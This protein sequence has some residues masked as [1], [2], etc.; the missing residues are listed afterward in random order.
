MGTDTLQ[1]AKAR[2]RVFSAVAKAIS[3]SES[4]RSVLVEIPDAVLKII[5][6]VESAK[7]NFKEDAISLAYHTATVTDKTVRFVDFVRA[8]PSMMSRIA[9]FRALLGQISDEIRV[10]VGRRSV[11]KLLFN[12]SRSVSKLARMRQVVAEAIAVIQFGTMAATSQEVE[13]MSQKQDFLIRRQKV[14]PLF[15]THL[16]LGLT[17]I[18]I[19]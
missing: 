2:L 5:T 9:E 4:F 13:I 14:I 15:L 8:S 7:G 19:S 16:S 1:G 3:I 11:R 17:Q 6:T 12:V 18:L 10:P